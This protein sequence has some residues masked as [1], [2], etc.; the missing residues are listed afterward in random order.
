MQ[1]TT[2]YYL[3]PFICKVQK[4]DTQRQKDQWLSGAEGRNRIN[5]QL[6]RGICMYVRNVA[7]LNYAG[8]CTTL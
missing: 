3:I 7:K 4:R 6:L 2:Y 8:L 1:K 5:C